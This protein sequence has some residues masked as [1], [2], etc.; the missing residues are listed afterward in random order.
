MAPW[1]QTGSGNWVFAWPR[2]TRTRSGTATRN[3]A[4]YCGG[5]CAAGSPTRTSTTSCR[6]CSRRSGASAAGSTRS[7]A[8]RPGC[9]RSRAAGPSTTCGPG[10]GRRS[11]SRMPRRCPGR[12]GVT[13]PAGWSRRRICRSPWPGCPTQQREAIEMAYYADLTQREIAERL[14][15]P[16][17]TI[18]ARTS[19]GLRRLQRADRVTRRRCYRG[20]VTGR[21]AAGRRHPALAGRY[22]RAVPDRLGGQ[23]AEQVEVR[24]LL[25]V[26]GAHFVPG[27]VGRAEDLETLVGPA[28]GTSRR[29]TPVPARTRT[30]GWRPGRPVRRR[31]T[32]SGP[33]ACAQARRPDPAAWPRDGCGRG[34]VPVPRSHGPCRSRW[35]RAPGSLSR[36]GSSRPCRAGVLAPSQLPGAPG[37]AQPP[38]PGGG[39][40]P[41]QPPVPAGAAV[42]LYPGGGEAL[43]LYP[44]GGEA[45]AVVPGGRR[46]KGPVPVV[47]A[48][49]LT[50]IPG[51]GLGESGL[52]GVTVPAVA[53][54]AR[55]GRRG[56][57][58]ATWG[59]L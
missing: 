7:A 38:D 14:D 12:T 45:V 54:A 21:P 46:G 58:V 30:A 51:P 50:A 56:G 5:T 53:A 44:A 15:V 2:P 35:P 6:W 48:A 10:A 34:P 11:R 29:L 52:A 55:R 47:A 49:R 41:F 26:E 3:S 18:K 13:S 24:R 23:H 42:P 33:A 57:R 59:A 17:G 32:G 28:S 20:V 4:R 43:P 8:W 40:V 1:A 9:S 22:Q 25:I 27:A 39:A 16:L 31:W 36:S 37:G 19:R